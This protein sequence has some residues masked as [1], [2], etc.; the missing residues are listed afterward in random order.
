MSGYAEPE[1]RIVTGIGTTGPD[2]VA[3]EVHADTAAARDALAHAVAAR[4]LGSEHHGVRV[5]LVHVR[6][7]HGT[8]LAEVWERP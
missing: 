4:L 2:V 1:P 5:V 8:R 3:V 7:V 6:D